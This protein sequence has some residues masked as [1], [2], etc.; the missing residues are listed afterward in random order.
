MPE[1]GEDALQ[2]KEEYIN[3]H[4]TFTVTTQKIVRAGGLMVS[5]THPN[6]R[7]AEKTGKS[8]GESGWAV[9]KGDEVMVFK[10][11]IVFESV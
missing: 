5:L 8:T 3:G 6:Q 1:V 4:H 2:G 9:S 11:T 7:T 10:A